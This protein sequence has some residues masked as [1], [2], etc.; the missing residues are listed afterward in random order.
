MTTKQK[1]QII[2]LTELWNYLFDQDNIHL[3]RS[4]W[5]DVNNQTNTPELLL[6]LSFKDI[7]DEIGN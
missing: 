4:L 2:C 3:Y 1:I 5:V 6:A 7:T